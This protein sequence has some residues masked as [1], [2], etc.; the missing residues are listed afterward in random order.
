MTFEQALISALGIVTSA[1][2]AVCKLLWKR[3]EACEKWRND[4]EGLLNE[5]SQKLGAL[6]SAVAFFRQCKT[7][8]CAFTGMDGET[9]SIKK[10]PPQ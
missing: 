1:L 5:L 2:A 8:G 7:N 9:F 10:H 4:K 3:S 6:N